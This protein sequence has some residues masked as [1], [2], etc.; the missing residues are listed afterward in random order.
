MLCSLKVLFMHLVWFENK[1][2][3]WDMNKDDEIYVCLK[4][5][6][7]LWILCSEVERVVIPNAKENKI[8]NE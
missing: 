8:P 2:I 6:F 7:C 1:F 4:P 5:R 3:G